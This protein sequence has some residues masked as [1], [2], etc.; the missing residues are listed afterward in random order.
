MALQVEE[1]DE[2]LD[3]SDY[4]EVS[5]PQQKSHR[6]QRRRTAAQKE[7]LAPFLDTPVTISTAC[8][9]RRKADPVSRR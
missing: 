6:G 9:R 5:A 2:V 8:A 4:D 3:E 1:S 7:P